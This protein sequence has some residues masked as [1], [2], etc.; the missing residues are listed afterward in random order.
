M[1]QADDSEH[2]DDPHRNEGAF[3]DSSSDVADRERLVLTP[4]DRVEDDGRADVRDD[5]EELQKST[6]I[7][8]VVL[9]A[10]SDVPDRIIEDWLEEREGPDRR[11]ERDDE[12]HPEYAAVPLVL[13]HRDSPPLARRLPLSTAQPTQSTNSGHDQQHGRRSR[14]R[15]G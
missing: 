3:D 5:E 2:E 4:R 11:N 6:Q 15:P 13:I 1:S 9:P 12:Q 14:R 10:T 8:L 7:N